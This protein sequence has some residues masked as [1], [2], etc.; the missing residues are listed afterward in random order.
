MAR[1]RPYR[2]NVPP[3][4]RPAATG[5][6]K[7]APLASDEAERLGI[8]GNPSLGRETDRA[9]GVGERADEQVSVDQATSLNAD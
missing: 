9:G 2:Q 6:L 7:Q 5:R 8:D 4:T 1:S 3:T